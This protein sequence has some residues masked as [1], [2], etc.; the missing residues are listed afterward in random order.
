MP[1]LINWDAQTIEAMKS[2]PL[3]ADGC[4]VQWL[5]GEGGG[6]VGGGRAQSVS[7]DGCIVQWDAAQKVHAVSPSAAG[8]IIKWAAAAD[9]KL[10]A[11]SELG[12]CIIDW[13]GVTAEQ[14]RAKLA[15]AEGGCIINW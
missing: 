7:P 3:E 1:C 5:R 4:I 10:Q 6:S 8:C 9:Q 15:A 12:G 2:V 13:K 11:Y 14:A